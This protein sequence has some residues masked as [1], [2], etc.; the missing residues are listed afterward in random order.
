MFLVFKFF[1]WKLFKDEDL[2]S[3]LILLYDWLEGIIS[4]HARYSYLSVLPDHNADVF[5]A[6]VLIA[7]FSFLSV[8]LLSVVLITFYI[9]SKRLHLNRKKLFEARVV[10]LT[11]KEYGFT[12]LLVPILGKWLLAIF[13]SFH[14]FG[15]SIIK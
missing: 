1:I 3:Y 2:L 5:A 4:S 9:L 11:K 12:I 15:I 10:S 7:C 13:G 14:M 6:F 8:I